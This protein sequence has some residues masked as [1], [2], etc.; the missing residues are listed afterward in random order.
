MGVKAGIEEIRLIEKKFGKL[1]ENG[2]GNDHFATREDLKRAYKSLHT[3]ITNITEYIVSYTN[4]G[5][6]SMIAKKPLGG[7]SCAACNVN[8]D[9]LMGKVHGFKPWGPAEIQ[10][11]RTGTGFSKQISHMQSEARITTVSREDVSS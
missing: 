7:W 9:K 10:I 3:H 2:S 4:G 1:T 8:L 11:P 6:D 5:D